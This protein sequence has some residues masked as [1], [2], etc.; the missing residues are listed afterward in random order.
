M[1]SAFGNI[2]AVPSGDFHDNFA[3]ASDLA[4]ASEARIQ[5]QVSSHVETVS[6]IIVHFGEQP[7]ALFYP[8]MAGGAGAVTTAGVLQ[9]N[10]VVQSHVKDGFR[11]AM[12]HVAQLAMLVLNGFSAG[13]KSDAHRARSRRFGGC[14]SR[15]LWF[16]LSHKIS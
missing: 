11:L 6:F 4:L 8:D 12:L 5:L 2:V 14:R 16:F 7:R 10:A 9:M 3:W 15:P 13:Q 1:L